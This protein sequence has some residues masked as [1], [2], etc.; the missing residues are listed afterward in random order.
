M[1]GCGW[2]PPF[3]GTSRENTA[4][5]RGQGFGLGQDDGDVEERLSD[6]GWSPERERG[7][8]AHSIAAYDEFIV[9]IQDRVLQAKWT[10]SQIQG[11]NIGTYRAVRWWLANRYL[12]Q[13]LPALGIW[14]LSDV[15]PNAQGIAPEAV[16]DLLL[17][18]RQALTE[19]A[20]VPTLRRVIADLVAS[21]RG[22]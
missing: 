20:D 8:D 5:S 19:R 15:Y 3:A 10:Q 18:R 13:L 12:P 14:A 6:L 22:H 2:L 7:L 11:H 16:L 21:R 1:V 4:C 9:R 17:G